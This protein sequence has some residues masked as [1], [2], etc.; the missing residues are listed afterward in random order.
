MDGGENQNVSESTVYSSVGNE[1][2]LQD[3]VTNMLRGSKAWAS[4]PLLEVWVSICYTFC[5]RDEVMILNAY[6]RGFVW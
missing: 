5:F 3:G 2:E 6:C 1:D 4:G